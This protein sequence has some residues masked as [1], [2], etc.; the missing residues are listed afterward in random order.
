MLQNLLRI[1]IGPV[2]GDEAQE[3][4][5][6]ISDRLGLKKIMYCKEIS[7]LRLIQ[8]FN[9]ISHL[10]TRLFHFLELQGRYFPKTMQMGCAYQ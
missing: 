9:S 7:V 6:R 10:S 8:F 4:D 1:F 3:K 5:G 2:V